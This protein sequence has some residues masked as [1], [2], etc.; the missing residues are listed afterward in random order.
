[1]LSL[2]GLSKRWPAFQLQD[3]SFDL[4]G[5]MIMGLVG[6][7]GAGKTTL[8]KI[9]LGLVRP[10][11]GEI[12]FQGQ[13]LRASGPLLR[14]RIA[15]VSDEPRLVPELKLRAL[16]EATAR[17]YPDWNEGRWTR[18]MGEF[19]LDPAAKAG[20]LSLGM[21]TKFAL[22]LALSR[23]ADLLVLDEP[24]TG[25]DPGFRRELIQRLSGLIQD[26]R[27]SILFSTH[28]T[29]DLESRVDLV[30]LMRDG[31]VVFS[32][33]QD[34]LRENWVLVKGGL[35]LLDGETRAGF[36]GLRTTPHGFEGLSEDG[37]AARRRFEGRALVERASLEDI[38]VLMGRR[39]AHA[40]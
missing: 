2:R 28:I 40:A 11:A 14:R 20:T 6:A 15:Y 18:L 37:A 26:E 10:D 36:A 34:A 35:E 16:K 39:K 27:R 30:T 38:V 29:S 31:Q 5:G 9:A 21:R 22:S 25:L 12:R 8:L 19:G 17:F 7:N 33:D 3:A 32:L 24:T 13:D 1:M 4:P 23:D